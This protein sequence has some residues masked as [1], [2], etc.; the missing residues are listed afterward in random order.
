MFEFIYSLGVAV[1]QKDFYGKSL[2]DYCVEQNITEIGKY[3][4][5]DFQ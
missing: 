4:V 2:Y 5:A 1:K 3:K